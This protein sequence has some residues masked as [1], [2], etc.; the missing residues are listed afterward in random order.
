[1]GLLTKTK[2]KRQHF[3]SDEW[4]RRLFFLPDSLLDFSFLSL[5]SQQCIDNQARKDGISDSLHLPDPTLQFIKMRPLMDQAIQPIGGKPLLVWKGATFT[6]IVVHHTEAADGEK[7][8]VMFIGTGGCWGKLQW[9]GARDQT[10]QVGFCL[11]RRG[12]AGEGGEL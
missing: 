2:L 3:L 4:L 5:F 1:M 12:H 10:D 11:I 8:H 6:R 7:Y 9:S